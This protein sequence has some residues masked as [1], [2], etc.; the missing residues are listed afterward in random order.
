MLSIGG[1]TAPY[2]LQER[3]I[4]EHALC[5]SL[6]NVKPPAKIHSPLRDDD[7][8]PSFSIY[9]YDGR[10]FYKDWG[11][12][13]SGTIAS[14]AAKLRGKTLSELAGEYKIDATKLLYV[15][16]SEKKNHSLAVKIRPWR[17]SDY[18]YWKSFGINPEWLDFCDVHPV[19]RIFSG[20]GSFA[21]DSLSFAYAEHKD[22]IDSVKV[23]QPYS[24]IKWL[25]G[26]DSSVWDLWRQL[27]STGNKIILTSSRKDAMCLWS[28][29]DIPAVCLQGEGYIPKAHVVQQIKDRFLDVYVL[30]DNDFTSSVNHGREFGKRIAQMFDLKQIEIP[31]E[32]KSKDPSDLLKNCG[33]ETLRQV[34][35]SSLM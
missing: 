2:I 6:F 18:E 20:N 24:K 9:E 16:D 29:T 1:D 22:D 17:A 35:A 21:A 25:S 19:S 27:P 28:N 31:S 12:G 5:L 30:Y 8:T 4:D 7:K 13:E 34:I 14:L 10:V 3:E 32:Y 33:R 15:H 26:H 23:Y 11:T